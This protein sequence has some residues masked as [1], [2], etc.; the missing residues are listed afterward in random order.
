MMS[1]LQIDEL[2]TEDYFPLKEPLLLGYQREWFEDD[3][4]VKA[5]E[6]SRRTGLTWAEAAS[7]AVTASKPKKRGG[8]NCFYIGSRK[9]MAL[10]YISAVALFARA[11]NQAVSQI[12]ESIF[13]DDDKDILTYVVRFPNSGFKVTAL[14]SRPSNLRGMQG[15]VV[16]DEAA[17]QES[18]HELL[19]AAMALLMWG[20]KVRMISTHNGVNNEFNQFIQEVRAGKKTCSIHRITLDDAL[21]D[22]LYKR[23]CFVTNK[24]W[25][26]KEQDKW[27]QKLID[28]SPTKE[29]AD[30]EYFCVPSKSGGCAISRVV[31]EAA[32]S[33]DYPVLVLEK[34]DDF[35][36]WPEH[37]RFAEV[38]KWCEEFLLPEL[39]KLD[40]NCRHAYGEDFGRVSDSTDIAP[41]RIES[42]LHRTVPFI[43]E[44]RNIP[45]KQQEQ[46]LFY[47]VDRLPRLISGK[48]DATGN[49][50]YLAEQ[51]RDKY[52][53]QHGQE[54]KLSNQWYLENMPKLKA[55]FEDQTI[56]VPASDDVASDL[57]ALKIIDG[58]IKLPA[59]K[60][61]SKEGLKRHGDSAIAIAMAY[62]ASLENGGEI[63]YIDVPSSR[64]GDDDDDYDFFS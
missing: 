11:F 36:E 18:L 50:A 24:K 15:Y 31:I 38:E 51:A 9:E 59:T 1:D 3:S 64:W 40:K 37:L 54:I 17:F 56:T 41:I 46:V 10:E 47:I 19:K 13:E 12:G 4:D 48:L 8:D 44:L 57:N 21:A 42:N 45:F 5:A 52:G 7:N 2:Q 55:A 61:E 26:Q 20:S 25:S 62:S 30:E 63:D 53:S 58:I 28:N 35:I 34:K 32:M 60:N 39:E 27:R 33:K 23:I 43:A 6:K 14:S 16:I 29:A 49:G 22:G